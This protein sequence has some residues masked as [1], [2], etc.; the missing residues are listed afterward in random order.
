[1]KKMFCC[2]ISIL[3]SVTIL[4]FGEIPVF[5]I[6]E[7]AEE[8]YETIEKF[9]TLEEKVY[10]NATVD[11]EF[12][13]DS[14]LVVLKND[15]SLKFNKYAKSDFDIGN[16]RTVKDLTSY[17]TNNMKEKYEISLSNDSISDSVT[18]DQNTINLNSSNFNS[19][20]LVSDRIQDDENY[21]ENINFNSYSYHQ[22][23][24]IDLSV[25][26]KQA[27]LDAVKEL[28]QREDVLAAHPDYIK[29]YDTVPNDTYYYKQW[30]ASKISLPSAW[31]ITKGSKTVTVG[32]IDSG[33]KRAH[34]DLTNNVDSS[35]SKSFTG[36]NQ[37]FV[38]TSGHGTAV[39]GIIGAVG[40]NSKGVSGVCWNVKLVSLKDGLYISDTIDAINYAEEKKIDILNFSQSVSSD[41]T[42]LK[43]AIQNY[44]GLFVC[45]AGNSNKNIDNSSEWVYPSKYCL[46][47][48]ISVAAV[49]E[50]NNLSIWNSL[51]ASNYG[52]NTVNVAAP[53][54]DLYTT[55]I[56]NTSDKY[57]RSFS[58][59]SS[60]APVVAGVAALVKSKYPKLSTFGVRAA[61]V[62]NVDSISSLSGK[63]KSGGRVNAYKALTNV[64]NRKFT[65]VYNKNGG[66]GSNMSNTTVIYGIEKNLSVN[67]YTK[68]GYKFDGWYAKR[69]SDGKWYYKGSSGTGWYLEGSQPSGYKKYLYK[70]NAVVA[71]TSITKNDTVTMYAQ[72]QPIKYT[73]IFNSNGGS[74]GSSMSNQTITYGINTKITK[75]IYSK[76]GYKFKGWTAKRT[77]DSK[78]LFTDGSNSGWYVEGTQP[79]GFY[80]FVYNDGATI[81]KTSSVNGDKVYMYAQWTPIKYI[82][83]FDSNGGSSSNTMAKQ[84]ITYGVNT[85][86]SKN[87]YK[88]HGYIFAGWTAHRKSDNKWFF[89][90]GSN[91]GWY[92][93]GTQPEDFYKFIYND[94]A[95]VAKTSAVDGDNVNMYAQWI[96]INYTIHFN[97]NGGYAESV[98]PDQTITYGIYS[99]LLTNIY[100]CAGYKFDGWHAYRHSDNKWYFT[101][102][103]ETGWCVDGNQP[104]GYKKFLYSDNAAVGKTSAVNGDIVD[105]YAQWKMVSE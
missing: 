80:K 73:L 63:V 96:P 76:Y 5:A 54:T 15:A 95:T 22:I 57:Y 16:F 9:N 75:N 86:L 45:S 48:M 81:S 78:W 51:E 3:L 18:T 58:G 28:E 68:T 93:E 60:S 47:N 77:S 65:V 66:S 98:M 42:A 13:D 67:T 56:G 21:T 24:K 40:N 52:A 61:V 27:V 99:N 53:G 100:T 2:V 23:L 10:C 92:V 8:S 94:E 4:T 12:C 105:M 1:M 79:E 17:T 35:L 14:V 74:S 55:D 62:R 43:S 30:A 20:V 46:P 64:E 70:D 89:T 11:D 69:Q 85:R 49:D 25:K 91:E 44:S 82:I 104:E 83:T 102:D 39:A 37:P 59:T 84:T 41:V 33:I 36:D 103:I 34:S 19:D 88:N 38:D 101:N 71:H 29:R 6:S 90:D 72:W 87:T 31:N 50:S 97:P 26:S 7:V 32:I